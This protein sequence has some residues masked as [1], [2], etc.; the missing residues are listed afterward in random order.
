MFFKCIKTLPFLLLFAYIHFVLFVR[1]KVFRKKNK[2]ALMTSFTLL[3]PESPQVKRYLIS[4]I[5]KL[6]HELPHNPFLLHL[7]QTYPLFPIAEPCINTEWG[8]IPIF[9]VLDAKN[10][11]NLTP[12]SLFISNYFRFYQ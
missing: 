11:K 1:V 10:E 7:V 4:S 9:C 12:I 3:L 2:T 6:V 8:L 5:T